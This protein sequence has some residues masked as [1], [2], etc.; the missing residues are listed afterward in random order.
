[1][2]SFF[3]GNAIQV[4]AVLI[5]ATKSTPMRHKTTVTI[6][7]NQL[8]SKIV[9][10]FLLIGAISSCNA[11]GPERYFDLAVLNSNMMTGFA[12]EGMER[13]LRDPSVKMVDGNKDKIEPMKRKEIVDGKITFFEENLKNLKPTD[14]T[15][16]I[17]SKSIS[18][19]EYILPVYKN[20]YT[21]LAKLYDEKGDS[22]ELELL[23]RSINQKYFPEFGKMLDELTIA[24]KAFA[25]RHQI[26]V[27]WGVG[28]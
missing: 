20:E 9:C 6:S 13:E 12:D 15:K 26:K 23:S 8:L 11:P 17:V 2:W 19:H 3:K 14:D 1:L 18:L 4:T 5:F 7:Q 21:Q 28:G 25:Q 10:A 24:G 22:G 27:N 16:E